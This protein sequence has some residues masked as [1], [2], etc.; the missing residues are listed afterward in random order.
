MKEI[1]NSDIIN[2][3]I[4]PHNLNL[5]IC[6]FLYEILF[7]RSSMSS[8]FNNFMIF[9]T[10]INQQKCLIGKSQQC[11]LVSAF[12]R[13]LKLIVLL[14]FISAASSGLNTTNQWLIHA[15]SEDELSL[16]YRHF[17]I[18]SEQYEGVW[19]ESCLKHRNETFLPSCWRFCI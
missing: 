16:H 1:I 13:S 3:M 17:L 8:N 11:S 14:N 2:S 10:R 6:S 5:Q 18:F 4:F 15:R 12:I 19:S 9:G 7:V